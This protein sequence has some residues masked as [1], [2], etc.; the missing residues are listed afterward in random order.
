MKTCEIL[1]HL[2]AIDIDSEKRFR[3]AAGDVERA[4]FEHFFNQQADERH[5]F[6][7]EL[8]AVQQNL[9]FDRTNS[10]TFGGFIDRE[11]MDFSV[12]M[13]KGDTG[14]LEWCRHDDEEIIGE[15]E[16]ALDGNP[17]TELRYIVER[18]LHDIRAAV[19]SEE[20]VLRLFGGPRS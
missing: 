9:G 16:K 5:R 2:I 4:N 8:E 3:H 14:I 10:G 19:V 7:R 11:A 20:D 15:Y 6:A 1:E 13:S 17:P 18:Q 12:A